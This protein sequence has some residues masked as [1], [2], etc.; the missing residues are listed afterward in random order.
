VIASLG[1]P[2]ATDNCTTVT[3]TNDAPAIFP[4]GTTSVTWTATDAVGN[5]AT[6]TQVITVKTTLLQRL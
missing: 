3:V 5:T 6:A 2:V 1:N 4:L